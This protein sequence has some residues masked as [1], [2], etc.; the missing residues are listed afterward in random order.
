MRP[1]IWALALAAP[2]G[3]CNALLGEEVARLPINAVSTAENQV[4]KEAS[5]L[6]RKDEEV[7]IWSDM[8]LAYEGEQPLRFQ[9][10]VTKD[11]A[12]FKQLEIDPTVK[13]LTV[14]EVKTNINGQIDWRF[15]AKNAELKVPANGTY[16]F[17]ARLVAS[18]AN[19]TLKL[20]KAELVLKK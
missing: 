9:V 8:D 12:P 4:V 18:S 13:N 3:A 20:T 15:T 10:V 5:L 6:L 2:L 1:L 16:V 7:G 11:G 17:K 14:G 19:P